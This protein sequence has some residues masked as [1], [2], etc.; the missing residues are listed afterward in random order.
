MSRSGGRSPRRLATSLVGLALV[1]GGLSACS[2]TPP[3]AAL[4]K[5]AAGLSAGDFG[6]QRVLTS[7]NQPV[8][9]DML[10]KLEGDL[11]GHKPTVKIGKPTV[12]GSNATATL[13]YSWPVGTGVNWEYTS[14]VQAKKDKDDKWQVLFD[15][16]TLHPDLTGTEKI[17]IKHTAA[18]RG[19]ILDG[20]GA[21]LTTK[22]KIITVQIQPNEVTDLPGTMKTLDAALKSIKGDIGDIDLTEATDKAKA[23][24]TAAIDI[25]SLREASYLKIRNTIHDLSGMYFSESS[26]VLGPSSTFAKAMLGQVG[27]VTKEMMDKNPGKY[28]L[29]DQVGKGGLQERYDDVLGGS[30]G[31]SVVIPGKD[32][33]S[34]KV[35]FKSDPKPG[36]VVKTTLDP[37]VQN[38]AEAAL[39]GQ[40]NR[41]ALVAVRVS[42]GAI[43]AAANGPTGSD[44]NLALNAQVPPGSTFK[45]ITALGLLENGSVNPDTVVP[46][47]KEYTAPGGT[48]IHNAHDF[49]L[50]DVPLH[51]AFAKSCNTAFAQLGAKL[52]PD[53]LAATAKSVGIGVPWDLGTSAY[54]GTVAS[55]ADTA[56][57]AAAAFGQGKTQVSP[58]ALAGAVAGIAHGQWQQPKL[59]T[60][61]APAKAAP[62]GPQLKPDSV[63]ALKQM[64]REVVTD[65]TA[66]AIK[67]TPGDP[68][69]GKTGTA[70]YDTKDPNKTHSWFIGFRGDIAFA[71]FVENGG[72]STDASVPIAGKFFT[73]LG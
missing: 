63:N 52:G 26:R 39:T 41:S 17:T 34:D 27:D 56:E 62:A 23:R 60:E 22:Q 59:V 31:V 7:S 64:M 25:V 3:D 12:K 48:P 58:V 30:P 49:V 70:E 28:Q 32:A 67:G 20:S 55:G 57:Q 73:T 54:S 37:K 33:N 15:P 71:V 47:P 24:G 21:P 6:G 50:G 66:T 51:V 72:L 19:N 65:G 18:D 53:G 14:V 38:A 40:Q 68:I 4:G 1:A 45:A 36:Q 5:F 43:L 42:D 16:S 69:Y 44:L 46:C 10:T 13:S 2:S 8:T 35:L 11:A 9:K 29:G 61:P